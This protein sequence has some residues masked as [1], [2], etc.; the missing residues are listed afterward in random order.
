[1]RH[2]MPYWSGDQTTIEALIQNWID[3]ANRLYPTGDELA[4]YWLTRRRKA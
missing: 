3:G 1:M 2:M 4:C